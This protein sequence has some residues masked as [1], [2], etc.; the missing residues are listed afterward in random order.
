[1]SKALFVKDTI[2]IYKA[3]FVKDKTVWCTSKRYTLFYYL[4]HYMKFQQ[5]EVYLINFPQ[6]GGNEFYGKHYA[7][8]LTPPDK[9][10]GTLLVAPLT[11]KKSGKKYRGGITIENIK[12][13]NTPS[14]PKAYAYV[15]KIQEIDKR[16][17][18]YKTKKKTDSDGQVMLDAAGKE[19]YDKV[20]R[21]AYK[22]DTDDHKKLLDKIKEVLGLDLY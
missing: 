6:K 7:I 19:L 10:D 21:P 11:G 5:G 13:Q 16:K 2:F 22:L 8:I 20:Y 12:Y 18:V 4:E 14:K 9:A 17:I 3:L 15:R 1:M